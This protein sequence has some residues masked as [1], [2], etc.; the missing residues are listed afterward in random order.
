MTVTR[1]A[2]FTGETRVVTDVTY[3]TG[4]GGITAVSSTQA[5]TG[6]YSYRQNAKVAFGKALSAGVAAARMGYWQYMVSASMDTLGGS[7][8]QSGTILFLASNGRNANLATSNIHI[9]FD[10]S[11]GL[12]LL[13]RPAGTTAYTTL[14]SATMPTQYST[15]G[16]WFHVGIT[17][18]IDSV[19]GFVSVYIDG[20]RVLNYQ[21][22]T[23]LTIGTGV[24][25]VNYETTATH[26]MG[27]GAFGSTG[28]GFTDVYVDD[29]FIDSIVGESDAPV[30]SRRFLMSLPTS[31]G[32]DAEWTAVPAV[33]NY[34]NVD[35]NPND[36]DTTYNKALAADLR[37]TFNV[38]DIT[39]PADHRIVAVNV[40]PFVKRLDSEIAHQL[41]VHAWDGAQYGD[42]ADLDLSMSYDVP[43]FA[44]LTTQPDGSD[45]DES[46]F[47]AMQ[48]GYRSRGTF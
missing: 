11:N 35:D 37:D 23:R 27:S 3:I 19:D 31:A 32:V 16:T 43:V 4:G 2:Q 36:G 28:T 8:S 1:L 42:S 22:D 5:K 7:G 15:T 13:R 48:F 26:F 21:G 9:A 25:T 12:I 40:S 46:S 33:A 47:N 17:L 20:V 34:L 30:P 6:T 10:P 38:T 45:W 18:K 29:M 14:A 24:G 44:R 39:L 41:S